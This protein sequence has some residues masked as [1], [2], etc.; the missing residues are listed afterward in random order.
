[1]DPNAQDETP[2]VVLEVTNAPEDQ[3]AA[4]LQGSINLEDARLRRLAF[5]RR[6]AYGWVQAFG[7]YPETPYAAEY[8]HP[9]ELKDALLNLCIR[10]L[11]ILEAEARIDLA[12]ANERLAA[13]AA[14]RG[15]CNADVQRN[16]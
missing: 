10:A 4:D 2:R 8:E 16:G 13:A 1:M 5:W 3:A 12:E 7:T 9:A 15:D 6:V 11:E 14:D